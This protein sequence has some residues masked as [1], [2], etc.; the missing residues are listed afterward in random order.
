MALLV[1]LLAPIGAFRVVAQAVS[2]PVAT[3]VLCSGMAAVETG[4]TLPPGAPHPESNCCA[5]CTVGLG[6]S[7][8]PGKTPEA[9]DQPQRQFQRVIWPQAITTPAK[10]RVGSNAQARAPPVVV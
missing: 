9:L 1:Q 7:P 6:S 10:A 4:Q 2:D 3:A 5:V 8:V